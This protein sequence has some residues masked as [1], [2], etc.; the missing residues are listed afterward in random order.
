MPPE[1][2]EQELLKSGHWE[3]ELT[4]FTRAGRRVTAASS[5]VLHREVGKPARILQ[6]CTDITARKQAEEKLK[7]AHDEL[8]RR[9]RARTADLKATVEQLQREVEERQQAEEALAQHAER[10]QDLYNNAPCGYQSLD[11]RR[12]RA[13]KRHRAGLAGVHPGGSIGGDEV[14]RPAEAR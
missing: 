6:I 7:R 1:E 8:E 10:V 3:G 14:F 13:D 9:V 2:I 5:W 4:H 12:L 11:S